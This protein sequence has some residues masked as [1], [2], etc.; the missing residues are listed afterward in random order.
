MICSYFLRETGAREKDATHG[1]EVANI[2]AGQF[3]PGVEM[4]VWR[5]PLPAD[6]AT[7]QPT[8]RDDLL[9]HNPSDPAQERNIALERPEELRR[10]H[11]LL[12][13]HAR[14]IGAPEEQ[15]RRLHL[16]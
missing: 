4:P 13:E 3:I 6:H 10:L 16:A 14:A 11:M 8:P 9:F 2:S 15:V 12:C 5:V 7:R 1:C